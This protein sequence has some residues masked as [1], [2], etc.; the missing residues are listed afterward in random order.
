[1]W[2]RFKFVGPFTV[3]Y[4]AAF[5]L[6]IWRDGNREFLLYGGVMAVLIAAVLLMDRRARFS[7]LVLWGLSI[8]GLLHMAGGNVTIPPEYANEGG[9]PVL[10]SLWIVPNLLKFD[11]VV[12]AFGFFITTF[13]CFE[14]ARDRLTTNGRVTAGAAILAAAAS[15]GFGAL[16]EIVEFAAVLLIPDTNVGGY[17]NTGWDLVANFCG[18]SLATIALWIRP[19]RR[20]SPA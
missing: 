10:Y 7:P 8:W 4:L 9:K 1:M 17:I 20:P 14:A 3:A 19:T 11:Q 15:M 13:V 6:L 12:H 5:G 18:A 16:N 2:R